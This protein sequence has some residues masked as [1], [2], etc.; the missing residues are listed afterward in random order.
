M[1]VLEGELDI[2]TVDLVRASLA[3]RGA[4]EGLVIDLRPLTFLDTSGIQLLVEAFRAARDEGFALRLLRAR[5]GVQRVFGI[6]GIESV[7][8]FADE[9]ADA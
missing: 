8:P 7:L 3:G 5:P 9:A 1:V 4:G 2:A 6:A